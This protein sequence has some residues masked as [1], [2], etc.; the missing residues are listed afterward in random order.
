[1]NKKIQEA[2][3]II[4][5]DHEI[6][7]IKN[8]GYIPYFMYSKEF[9]PCWAAQFKNFTIASIA[10]QLK[11]KGYEE[12]ITANDCYSTLEEALKIRYKKSRELLFYN[13]NVAVK[14]GEQII[15]MKAL[16]YNL[17]KIIKEEFI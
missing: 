13:P 3:F 14:M 15:S 5:E 1:M 4:N 11:H 16:K 8:K 9:L 6:R 17:E 2:N 7:F 10:L 12:A